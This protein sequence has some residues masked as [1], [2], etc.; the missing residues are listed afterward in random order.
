MTMPLKARLLSTTAIIIRLGPTVS[1]SW[2]WW[3][4]GGAL[5]HDAMWEPRSTDRVV[6]YDPWFQ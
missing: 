3:W 4:S 5:Y 1:S 6:A 2:P